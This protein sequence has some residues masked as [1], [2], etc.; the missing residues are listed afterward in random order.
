MRY[1]PNPPDSAVAW[2]KE[3]IFPVMDVR[4]RAPAGF[5]DIRIG[6]FVQK[7]PGAEY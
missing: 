3:N 4:N 6:A 5:G 7:V 1:P 2:I